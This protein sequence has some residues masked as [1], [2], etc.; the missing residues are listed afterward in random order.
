MRN[1]NATRE[2]PNSKIQMPN[3]AKNPNVKIPM[4]NLAFGL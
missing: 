2:M 4:S 3:E 1:P